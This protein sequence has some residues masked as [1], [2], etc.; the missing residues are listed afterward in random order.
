V[1]GTGLLLSQRPAG[2][3][4]KPPSPAYGCSSTACLSSIQEVRPFC[5]TSRACAERRENAAL[6]QGVG[7]EFDRSGLLTERVDRIGLDGRIASIDQNV[8]GR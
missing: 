6:G 8:G 1:S 7:K 3:S 2:G 4:A 5:S